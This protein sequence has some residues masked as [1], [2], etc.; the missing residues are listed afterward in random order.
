MNVN[1]KA[2]LAAGL[3]AS[4]FAISG[5]TQAQISDGVIKIGVLSDMSGLYSDIGG[6]GSTVAAQNGGRGLRRCPRRG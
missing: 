6:P 3:G 2:L 4:L 1:L 5:G